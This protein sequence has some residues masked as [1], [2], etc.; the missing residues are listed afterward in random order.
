M[1]EETTIEKVPFKANLSLIITVVIGVMAFCAAYYNLLINISTVQ[2]QVAQVY[3][4]VESGNKQ[5]VSDHA[6]IKEQLQDHESRIRDLE[7]K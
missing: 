2:V 4:T 1:S 3:A 5:N 6:V 7:K